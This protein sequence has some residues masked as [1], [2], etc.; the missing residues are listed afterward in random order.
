MHAEVCAVDAGRLVPP[1][2]QPRRKR[3]HHLACGYLAAPLSVSLMS[4]GALR[5]V[6]LCCC[7]NTAALYAARDAYTALQLLASRQAAQCFLS[8]RGFWYERDERGSEEG[9]SMRGEER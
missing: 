6:L 1:T 9:W 2:P 5:V 7:F 8:C 4:T 3:A